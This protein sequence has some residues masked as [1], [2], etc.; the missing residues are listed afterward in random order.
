MAAAI[1]PLVAAGVEAIAPQIPKLVTWL[2]SVFGHS[3]TS[4]ANVQTGATKLTTGVQILQQTLTNMAN[5]GLIPSASVVDPTMSSALAGAIQTVVNQ[6]KASG[7]LGPSTPVPA[8]T[9]VTSTLPS[10]V[11]SVDPAA[12]SLPV[13]SHNVSLTGTLTIS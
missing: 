9:S 5:A 13:G 12:V 3:S 2:E 4:P 11:P 7:Q 1:I 6:L 10:P 8:G